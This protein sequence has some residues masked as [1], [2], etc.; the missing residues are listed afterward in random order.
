MARKNQERALRQAAERAAAQQQSQ[1]SPE[2][3][4]AAASGVVDV[5]VAPP[6]P[7][8][9]AAETPAPAA[10]TPAAGPPSAMA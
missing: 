2:P 8:Q 4:F 6:D 3:N 7:L 9:S 10:E 1:S 5:I